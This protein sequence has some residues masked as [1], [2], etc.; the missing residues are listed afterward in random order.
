MSKEDALRYKECIVQADNELDLMNSD[1]RC[2]SNVLFNWVDELTRHPR[3]VDIVS[4]LIGPNFHCWDTLF[5]IKK[6]GDDKDVSFHQ[7]STYWNFDQPEKALT[8]WFAFDDVTSDHGPIEYLTN[9]SHPLP[10]ID[11]KTDTNLL[12]RGQTVAELEDT[13]TTKAICPAGYVL[14]HGPFTIH[15]SAA[16]KTTSDRYAMGMV[17]VST[18][19]KPLVDYSPESTVMVSGKDIY[20]HMLHDP[21]PSFWWEDNLQNWRA[22]YDRQHINYYKMKQRAEHV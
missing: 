1:Y 6:A 4:Q 2:K 22:A 17:F 20:N 18:E 5:W 15:G 13:N 10:H 8:V 7:D 16:N 12:M 3:V 14:V 11:I 21:Q 19:C 9:P